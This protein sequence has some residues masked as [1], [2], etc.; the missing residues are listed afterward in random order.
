M[1]KLFFI[2]VAV[3][4]LCVQFASADTPNANVP[5]QQSAQITQLQSEVL[6]LQ[7]QVDTLQNQGQV[8]SGSPVDVNALVA[9]GG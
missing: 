5:G 2:G 8:Q 7:S 9:T 1:R 3:T 4:A 6:A